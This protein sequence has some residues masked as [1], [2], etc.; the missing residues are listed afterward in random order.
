MIYIQS[1]FKKNIRSNIIKTIL[2]YLPIVVLETLNKWKV[3]II[4]VEQEYDS[5]KSRHDYRTKMG[6][7]YVGKE[8]SMEIGK[9]KDNYDKDRKP[10]CFNYNVYR[11]WQK[12]AESQREKKRQESII[13]VIKW[14]I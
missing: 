13:N 6:I 1:L 5:T 9:S 2:G 4:S 7:I 3:A 12:I 8:V 11:H 10:R 14:N